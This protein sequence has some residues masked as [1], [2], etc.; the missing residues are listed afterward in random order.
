MYIITLIT[1]TLLIS[2]SGQ[3]DIITNFTATLS[4]ISNVGPGLEKVGPICTYSFYS[5]FNTFV[6]A[7]VMIAGRLELVTLFVVFSKYFMN[8]NRV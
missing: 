7:I 3:G 2:L 8:P 5:G 4:C 1:A 6:L